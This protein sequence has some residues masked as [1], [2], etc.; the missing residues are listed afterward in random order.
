[1]TIEEAIKHIETLRGPSIAANKIIWGLQWPKELFMLKAF[2]R[3]YYLD[4]I[5]RFTG[6]ISTAMGLLLPNWS[7]T[8]SLGENHDW[9]SVVLGRSYPTNKQIVKEAA[10]IPLALIQAA[11][12]SWKIMEEE[13]YV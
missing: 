11:L 12:E 5:P 10:T 6:C 2:S 3:T 1:M 13:N 9:A 7:A 4:P 8:L